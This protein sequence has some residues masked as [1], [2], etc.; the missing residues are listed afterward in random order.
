[1]TA[2]RPLAHLMAVVIIMI[3]AAFGA[4]V[5]QAHEGHAHH[6]APAV[7][8]HQHTQAAPV[9]VHAQAVQLATVVVDQVM[10]AISSDQ[11]LHAAS[12]RLS[13]PDDDE[14]CHG[15]CC[16][17]GASCC[18]P[19][20]MLP[21]ETAA[22]LTLTPAARLTAAAEPFLAGIAREALPKPPRSFA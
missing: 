19:G 1:M 17:I 20:A 21:A 11:R 2:Y 22:L 5:A 3:T 6:S 8:H 9:A 16:S 15:V 10:T 14:P 7:A 13:T 12:A 18:V 4:S